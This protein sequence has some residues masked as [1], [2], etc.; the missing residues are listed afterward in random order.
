MGFKAVL[1]DMD[2][3]LLDFKPS[4]R[5][6]ICEC[7][8]MFDIG[9]CTDD[10]AMMYSEINQRRWSGFNR[11]SISYRET[12][13]GR[14]AE[15]FDA[16]GVEGVDPSRFNMEYQRLLGSKV[17]FNRN[18]ERTLQELKGK[19]IQCAVTNGARTAQELKI[20][21]TIMA[22]A[23]DHV[24]I[25]ECVGYSKP[26]R[27]FFDIVLETIGLAKEECIIVGDSLS[28]DIRGGMDSGI[29][30]CWY[31]PDSLPVTDGETPDYIISDIAD[32]PRIAEADE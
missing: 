2:G 1:W 10:I 28:S 27:R 25:S 21:S 7:F 20:R 8:R 19:V 16:L 23:F 5:Y 26:D 11:G 24:F 17:F 6:A 31:N 9:E 32:V 3:T 29:A 15:L 4:E 12:L 22:D 30:T 13:E 18:A 14:F